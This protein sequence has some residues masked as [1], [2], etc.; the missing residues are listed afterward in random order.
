MST[1]WLRLIAI[2]LVVLPL[3]AAVLWLSSGHETF[4]KSGKAVQVPVKDIFGETAMQWQFVPGPIAGFYIGL[5]FV[6]G[7]ALV[8]LAGEAVLLLIWW[9]GRRRARRQGRNHGF[10]VHEL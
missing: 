1:R 5:D 2:L 6:A 9:L 4:T 3:A 8:A 7:A 10:P